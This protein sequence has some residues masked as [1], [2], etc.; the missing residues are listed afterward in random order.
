LGAGLG[1]ERDAKEQLFLAL[2]N[3][4]RAGRFSRQMGQRLESLAGLVQAARIRAD[5]RL[6][7]EAIA[8]MALPDL[9]PVP[10]P[11][12]FPEGTICIAFGARN[13]H[14]PSARNPN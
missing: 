4:A 5:A 9:R 14:Y 12:L 2:L 13:H 6:R 7:D 3:R 10:G 11:N 8:A 1:S